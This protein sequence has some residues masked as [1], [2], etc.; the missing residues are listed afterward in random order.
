M[1]DGLLA[2]DRNVRE[3][4]G[5]AAEF[6]GLLDLHF[7]RRT[8]LEREAAAID[9]PLAGLE[10]YPAWRGRS[11]R[12]CGERQGL[13]GRRG[14]ARRREAGRRL[15]GRLEDLDAL[16][17]LDDAVLR[18]ETVRAAVGRQAAEADTIPFYADGHGELVDAARALFGVPVAARRHCGRPSTRSSPRPRPASGRGTRSRPCTTGRPGWSRNTAGW[19]RAPATSRRPRWR[20]GRAGRSAR[21]R[22]A[23]RWQAMLDEA[24]V[25]R[26][27][28]DRL[29][30]ERAAIS[31]A[32]GRLAGYRDRDE[33][34]AALAA[35]RLKVVERAAIEGVPWFYLEGW[36][37][38]AARAEAFRERDGAARARGRAGGPYRAIRPGLPRG[39]PPR[40]TVSSTASGGTGATGGSSG[41]RRNACGGRGTIRTSR[42]P[43]FPATARWRRG[44]ARCGRQERRSWPTGRRTP[45]ISTGRRTRRP[46]SRPA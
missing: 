26:P 10:D 13:A 16:C 5:G 3:G 41:A 27:H 33:A 9:R 24:D 15:A 4:D 44:Q 19:R 23:G 32:V 11:E 18:F 7:G 36:A 46:G 6:L 22:A 37:G 40:S 29:A 20:S 8:E 1:A 43:S 21:R 34:W 17:V 25:W 39:A 12:L 31:A 35:E 45:S 42:W 28:L 2:Y 14:R 30:D 38:F